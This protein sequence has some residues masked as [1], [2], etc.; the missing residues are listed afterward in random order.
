MYDVGVEIN[1]ASNLSAT[2]RLQI[3]HSVMILAIDS[4]FLAYK[5][6]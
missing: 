2:G 4:A 1:V 6:H 3:E 5:D